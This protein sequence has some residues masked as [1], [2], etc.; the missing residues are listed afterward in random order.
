M[1]V[2]NLMESMMEPC[3]MMDKATISDGAG[4]FDTAWVEGA[5]FNAFVRKETAPELIVAE[6]EG[7]KE[8][9]TVVVMKGVPLEYHDVFKRVS[10]GAV[11]RL[12]SNVLD[13]AAPEAASPPVKIA[14]AGCERWELT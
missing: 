3:I 6:K 7:V 9:F 13:D 14:K 12:T 5:R 2:V 11:F 10:D 8:T 1:P 4:G